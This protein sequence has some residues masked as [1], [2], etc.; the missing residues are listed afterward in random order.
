MYEKVDLPNSGAIARRIY[1]TGF[2]ISQY[3]FIMG[4]MGNGG[5]CLNDV[6]MF[7]T[8]RKTCKILN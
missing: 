6:L 3:F 5:E 4:G 8:E 1:A 2:M 7:N